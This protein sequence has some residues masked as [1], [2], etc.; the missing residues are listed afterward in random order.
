VKLSKLHENLQHE[1]RAQDDAD[2]YIFALLDIDFFKS[3][4]D[5]FGHVYGDEVLILFANTMRKTFRDDDMLF[6]YGGEEF[7][8]LLSKVSLEQAESILNRFRKNIENIT[9]PLGDCVTA[10]SGYCQFTNTVPLSAITERADK[11]LYY[12]KEHGR[13]NVRNY[14]N[15][16][17]N[18]KISD[19]VVDQ[20]DVELF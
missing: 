5:R 2:N 7:A 15:L 8:V 12:A 17:E 10:S 9:L 18:N 19:I 20:G 3:I 11:A 14:E 4:N 13:N 6:R 16:I 1:N